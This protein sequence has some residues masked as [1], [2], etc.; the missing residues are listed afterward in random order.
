[1]ENEK[2]EHE[3]SLNTHSRSSSIND[4]KL[5]QEAL[6]KSHHSSK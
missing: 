2:S 6:H 1:M 5:I 3:G 4:S